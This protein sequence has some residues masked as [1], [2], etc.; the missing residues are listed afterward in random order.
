MA[1][2][3]GGVVI[4]PILVDARSRAGTGR[5]GLCIMAAAS[6]RAPS[7]VPPEKKE[8]KKHEH[9]WS[10]TTENLRISFWFSINDAALINTYKSNLSYCPVMSSH[11]S[12]APVKTDRAVRIQ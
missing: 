10:A 9:I 1:T 3:G 4:R 5:F 11:F 12:P 8:H 2:V 7:P 6:A